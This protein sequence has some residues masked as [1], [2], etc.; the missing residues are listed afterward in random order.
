MIRKQLLGAF[1]ALALGLFALPVQAAPIS[2]PATSLAGEVESAV[3][4]VHRRHR[5]HHRHHHHGHRHH[6]HFHLR[7]FGHCRWVCHGYWHRGHCHGHL[8]RRCSW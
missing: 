1:G 3:Q 8:H 4:Q 5:H 7:H 2:S 6:H